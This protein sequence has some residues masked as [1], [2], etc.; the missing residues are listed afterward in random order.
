MTIKVL[1]T[2]MTT[3]HGGVESFLFNHISRIQSP[4]LQF[5]FWCNNEQCTY[6]K[7]LIA[8]GCNVF[9]GRSYGS[10]PIGAIHDIKVFFREHKYDILWENDSML[11]HIDTLRSAKKNGIKRIILHS[12][13]SKDMFSGLSGNAKSILHKL[14]RGQANRL[15]TDYWACSSDAGKFFFT[16]SNIHSRRYAFIPNAIDTANFSFNET[17]RLKKRLELGIA[18][19]TTVLG[20]VGRLQY[21]KNPEMLIDIFAS[22][23]HMNRDSLLLVVGTG[24]LQEKCER[25]TREKGIA[26]NVKF[27]GPR[28]D[29]PQLYQAMDAF[30]LPSRFEGLPVVLLEAQSAGLPCIV[31]DTITDEVACTPMFSRVGRDEGPNVWASRIQKSVKET[32]STHREKAFLQ[33]QDS[34][35]GLSE[36]AELLKRRLCG[37]EITSN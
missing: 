13:N 5:D 21:Q 33:V 10:D 24:E 6:E 4:E 18:N 8:L 17:D 20:F 22:Y 14:H 9:H 7:D 35:F 31:S 28:S 2:G 34:G 16:E 29:V 11:V 12:H 36:A 15:A 27:L 19:H 26:S 25:M 23:F 37:N 32:C 30:C 1:V 3:N